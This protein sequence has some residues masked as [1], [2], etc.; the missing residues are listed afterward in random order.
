MTRGPN[1]LVRSRAT[2]EA[3]EE[4]TAAPAV[5]RWTRGSEGGRITTSVCRIARRASIGSVDSADGEVT[6]TLDLDDD[7]EAIGLRVVDARHAGEAFARARL[8]DVELVRCDLSGCDFSE[9]VWQRVRLV[10]CR[11]SAIELPQSNLRHVTFVDCKLDDANFRLGQL[12]HVG[13]DGSV[14]GGADLVGAQLDD[15]SFAGSDLAGADFS[16]ARCSAVDLRGARLD[17]LRGVAALAGA[18]IGVDQLF[19]LA[20]A[21]AQALGLNV[22]AAE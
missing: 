20:P 1:D 18:T 11:A 5:E 17:G 4:D 14:L 21:L 15:V 19:G 7:G 9:S 22:K 3:T 2:R 16:N 13:F 12:H 10:D 6:A 8:V